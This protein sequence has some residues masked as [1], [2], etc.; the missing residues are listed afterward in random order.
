L[1]EIEPDVAQVEA[2]GELAVLLEPEQACREVE[3]VAEHGAVQPQL[4]ALLGMAQR[5][6]CHLA[7]NRRTVQ[8]LAEARPEGAVRADRFDLEA[9]RQLPIDDAGDAFVGQV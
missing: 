1:G 8:V 5:L 9:F 6:E 7:R 4:L 3:A 2:P